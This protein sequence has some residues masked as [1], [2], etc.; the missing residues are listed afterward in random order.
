MRAIEEKL[1]THAAA[2]SKAVERHADPFEIA[3]RFRAFL[4]VEN[5]RLRMAHRAGA[6]G[7]QTAAAR[8][9]ALDQVVRC[10]F[11]AA[12]W[13]RE[14]G[15]LPGGAQQGCA[16]VAVGGY[17]RGELAPFSDLDLLFLHTGRR[18]EQTRQLAGRILQLLWDAGLTVGHSFR[19]VRECVSASHT[20]PHLRTALVTTRLVAGNGALTDCLRASLERERTRRAE[21]FLSIIQRERDARYAAYGSSVCLQEPNVKESAGGLRDLHTALWAAHARHGCATLESLRARGL[22][23]D[24]ECARAARAYDL[25]WRVRHSAHALAGRKT[26]R[27]TL[28]LQPA[29]AEEF[30]YRPT[31]HLLASEKFMRDYYR[32]ARDLHVFGETLL[33]RACETAKTQTAPRRWS[34]P[35]PASEPFSIEDGRLRLHGGAQ[36]FRRRPLLIFDAFAL[37]Q[38]AGVPLDNAL[39]EAVRQSLHVVDRSLRESPAASEAFFKLLRRRGRVGFALRL[40]HE[41][42]FLS[43]YIPEFARVTLLIQHDLY[44]HYTVDEHTLK[45]IDAL[46]ELH[47]ERDR[48][49][50]NLRAAFDEI[51]DAAPLYLSVLLHDIGKG[52]G[53]GHIPRGARIAERVC[54]RLDLGEPVAALVVSTVRQH[55]LMA[56]TALRRDL[57]EPRV[58]AH[59]AAQVGSTDALRVLLLLT[60]ADLNG[61]GPGVWSDWKG[62][63]LWELYRRART[64]L[65]GGGD[66]ACAGAHD[67]PARARERLVEALAAEF[68]PSEVERHLALLPERYTRVTTT[69]EAAEHLRL[70]AGLGDRACR[71]R[72]LRRGP[73]STALTVCA[74][75]RHG[76]FR[77]IAGT[78]A[79][80]GVEILSAEVNTREDGVVIDVFILREAATRRAVEEHKY[81][82][83]ESALGASVAGEA[84][85]AALVERWRKN[86]SPRRKLLPA[87]ARRPARPSVVYDNDASHA[88]TLIEVRA[89]DETGL[90]YKIACALAASG[91]DIVCAKIA[92]EK[93]DAL[94]VFYVTD[95]EGRKLTEEE[96]RAA[97]VS[98]ADA[99]ADGFE[100]AATPG[101]KTG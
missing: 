57:G 97:E 52:Q 71:C 100:P 93:S 20:D 13:P 54:R 41:V 18:A 92:T 77:D 56:H 23:S 48:R 95:A 50:T 33:A 1:L 49:R 43:R 60:Y 25:L 64:H 40:M 21:E 65:A 73:D 12:T 32:S 68:P 46:D 27:L 88:A 35:R 37:A 78:L 3:G 24:E 62:T 4:K 9:L 38:A 14:G 15:A 83:I 91:L 51:T 84:D 17:G 10:A 75:D 11:R 36:V 42:G 98:L 39:R 63:L 90:A 6:Q 28:D 94:D 72:W 85:V 2:L 16:L 34:R 19:T 67:E 31:P 22:V 53:R 79:S 58:A 87:Q 26:D 81:P 7:R 29:V 30:G 5:Q 82:A 96:A 44:H 86:S 89:A 101:R 69:E 61:V 76:L 55:V 80:R 70:I 45:A 99:L 59:F 66:D 47:N 8:S 74:R